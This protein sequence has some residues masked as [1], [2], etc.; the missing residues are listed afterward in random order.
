MCSDYSAMR[1]VA[2]A[3]PNN[4]IRMPTKEPATGAGCQHIA[5]RT[6]NIIKAVESLTKRGISFLSVPSRYYVK[7]REKLAMKNVK[8]AE[9]ITL[10]VGDRPTIFMEIIQRE[11]FDG[12]GAENFKSL[13]EAFEREQRLRGRL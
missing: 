7:M 13:F 8:I 2:V 12:F 6:N 3:S 10:H 11:N 1:S 5:F 4:V 9:D